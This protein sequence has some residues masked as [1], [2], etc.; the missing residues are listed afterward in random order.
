MISI[1]SSL[2]FFF[3]IY[4]ALINSDAKDEISLH[5]LIKKIYGQLNILPVKIS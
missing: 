1:I 5:P 3:V 4:K 2:F